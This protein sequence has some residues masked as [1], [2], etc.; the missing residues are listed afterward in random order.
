MIPLI[1]FFDLKLCFLPTKLFISIL[2]SNPVPTALYI[3]LFSIMRALYAVL[4]LSSLYMN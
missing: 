1:L 3:P 4:A 2:K